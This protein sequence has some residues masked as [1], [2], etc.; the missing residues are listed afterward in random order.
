MLEEARAR[1]FE[2]ITE[3]DGRAVRRRDGD[4]RL[5]RALARLAAVDA[6]VERAAQE[7]D[8]DPFDPQGARRRALLVR[9][10]VADAAV[11]ARTTAASLAS[12]EQWARGPEWARRVADLDVFLSINHSAADDTLVGLEHPD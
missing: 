2:H 4:G 10:A 1:C 3:R 7:L 11:A 6:L 5:G 12:A 8:H 9:T